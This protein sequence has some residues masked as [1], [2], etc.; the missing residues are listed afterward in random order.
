VPRRASV[1]TRPEKDHRSLAGMTQ[2]GASGLPDSLE[3]ITWRPVANLRARTDVPPL[4][5][6][7]WADEILADSAWTV[8][9]C[10]SV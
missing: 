9:K 8:A 3:T 1:L 2:P 6:G 10:R 4:H 5:A 7:D